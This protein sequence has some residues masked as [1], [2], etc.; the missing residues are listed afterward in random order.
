MLRHRLSLTLLVILLA[1]G[2]GSR[3]AA[4]P[5]G[6][7]GLASCGATAAT[8]AA[9]PSAASANVTVATVSPTAGPPLQTVADV[10]LP[11]RATRFDYQEFDPTSGRLYLA[12]MGDG[13]LL[14]FDV[15]TRTV[16]GTIPNLPQVTGVLAPP[17]LGK[18]YASVTG[19]QNV[20]VIDAKTFTVATRVGSIGFPDGLD[21]APGANQVF[22]SDEQGGGE[23]VIAASTDRALATIDIGG[24][25]GNTHYDAGSGCILVA[26]QTRDELVA[27]DPRSDAVAARYPLDPNCQGPH[28]FLVDAPDRLAFVTCKDNAKLLVVDL[29]TMG[30]TATFSV[31]DGPDVLAFD[32]GPG[33]LYVAS[34]SGTVSVFTKQGRGLEPAGDY[35]APHAHTIAV[36]PATHL[37]YLPLENLNGMPVLRIMTPLS[38]TS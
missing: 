30:A 20:A 17:N 36:D 4:A 16:V 29:T 35:Q 19:D 26:V 32:P 23:L 11:G 38:P 25:A 27:I 10:P 34:E 7:S 14:A 33:R 1:A 2:F 13:Q 22:V 3:V 24:D 37:V 5:S 18:I 15:A 8:P 28:G 21:F 6:A 31:G 9:S 12:H